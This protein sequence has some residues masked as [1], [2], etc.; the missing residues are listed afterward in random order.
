MTDHDARGPRRGRGL[1]ASRAGL[2][3][4]VFLVFVGF[5]LTTEHRAHAFGALLWLAILACPL[6]HIFMHGGHGSHEGHDTQERDGPGRRS[7]AKDVA[8]EH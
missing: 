3:L 7:I 8:H 1:L 4:I 5:L 6:L 2:V